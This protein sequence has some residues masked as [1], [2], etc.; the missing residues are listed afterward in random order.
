MYDG[1]SNE[2]TYHIDLQ[3][4][5]YWFDSLPVF[6]LTIYGTPNKIT[7]YLGPIIDALDEDYEDIIWQY[8]RANAG[9]Q[10]KDP[11]YKDEMQ[12]A[13]KMVAERRQYRNRNL[14]MAK[15]TLAFRDR[16]GRVIDNPNNSEGL[17]VDIIGIESP[18]DL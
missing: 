13:D 5:V 8:I 15:Q 17:P 1:N 14:G 10:V 4:R 11:D 18:G 16:E 9:K 3:R 7:T 12:L 2:L 6:P